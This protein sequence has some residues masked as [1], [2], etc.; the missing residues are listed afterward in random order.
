MYDKLVELGYAIFIITARPK[1]EPGIKYV[2][3]QLRGLGYD[4]TPIPLSGIYMQPKDYYDNNLTGRFKYDVRKHIQDKYKVKIIFMV[5]DQ[6]T[7]IFPEGKNDFRKI[8]DVKYKGE[9]EKVMDSLGIIVANPDD[10]T[11]IGLYISC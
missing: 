11:S 6:F 8:K 1:T 3:K 7:D 10:V 4:L 5:G 9:S 2:A